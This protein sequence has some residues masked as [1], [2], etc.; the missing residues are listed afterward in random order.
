MARPRRPPRDRHCPPQGEAMTVFDW[1]ALGLLVMIIIVPIFIWLGSEA[2]LRKLDFS[3]QRPANDNQE[4][5][6]KK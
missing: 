1:L 4:K 5:K 3:S 6:P 2:V